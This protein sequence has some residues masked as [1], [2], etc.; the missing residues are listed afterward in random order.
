[1]K[2]V[3]VELQLSLKRYSNVQT[4]EIILTVGD[5]ATV[6]DVLETFNLVHGEV[7]V[8]LV[9]GELATETEELPDNATIILYPIFGG[10]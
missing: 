6:Q 1:V 10:G 4:N 8:V 5:N 7:G 9:N 2:K 3:K